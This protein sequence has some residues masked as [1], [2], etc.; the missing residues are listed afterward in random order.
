MDTAIRRPT[1]RA[2]DWRAIVTS[3]PLTGA[4]VAGFVAT[5]LA[6]VTGYWY[7]GLALT[8][9]KG[10]PDLGW[11]GFNG[12]L[13]VPTESGLAQFWTGAIFHFLTGM[14][15]SLGFALLLFPLFPWTNTVGGNIL[16]ALIFAWV[17]GTISALWWVPQLFP[18]INAGFFSN[19]LGWKTVFGIY[20]WHTIYG[21]NLGALYSP[22]PPEGV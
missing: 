12:L 19:H 15:F 11:P 2:I 5:H 22:L 17:L 13:L 8:S 1:E 3:R 14:A 18:A 16:K 21:V 9:G 4:L 6:T 7:H 20:L 10:L